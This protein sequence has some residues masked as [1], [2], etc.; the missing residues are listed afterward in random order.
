MSAPSKFPA[1]YKPSLDTKHVEAAIKDIKDFFEQR[2]AEALK[3]QR[4]TAPLFV[5]SGTGIND[6][7]NG[8][9]R[10]IR[11]PVKGDNDALVE[12]VQ[13]LAK[14]KRMALARYGFA[15]GEG[16]YTDMNAIRPDETLDDI[17]SIDRLQFRVPVLV[18]PSC[19]RR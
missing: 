17:H 11:F 19:G 14:W 13:S 15:V 18:G 3:L 8:V 1:N 2:L 5:R 7:L 9:E 6:D 4:V 12:I 10:P 16:L